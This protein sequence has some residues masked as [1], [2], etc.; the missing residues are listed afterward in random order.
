MPRGATPRHRLYGATRFT[1]P[2]TGATA[3]RLARDAAISAVLPPDDCPVT[4][5]REPNNTCVDDEVRHIL[6]ECLAME[7]DRLCTPT[8]M[9]PESGAGQGDF[10]CRALL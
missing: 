3:K 8:Y 2:H 7:M 4:D 6:D 5:I 10:A 9:S 1:R